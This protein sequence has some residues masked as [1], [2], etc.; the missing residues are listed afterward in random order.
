MKRSGR[1]AFDLKNCAVLEEKIDASKINFDDDSNSFRA[2]CIK[3]KVS[4]KSI[5]HCS[6]FRRFLSIM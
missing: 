1:K 2:G 6:L 4:Y 5:E 3:L